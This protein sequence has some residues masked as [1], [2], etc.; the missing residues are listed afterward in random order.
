MTMKTPVVLFR[1]GSKVHQPPSVWDH[2]APTASACALLKP[3]R[4]ELNKSGFIGEGAKNCLV[5]DDDGDDVEVDDD[6]DDIIEKIN[7]DAE[8]DV[9]GA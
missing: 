7:D 8:G 5:F 2:H 4:G 3:G 6:D 1:R 9:I